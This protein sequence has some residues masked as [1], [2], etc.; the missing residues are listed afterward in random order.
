MPLGYYAEKFKAI[1]ETKPQNTLLNPSQLSLDALRQSASQQFSQYQDKMP[2]NIQSYSLAKTKRYQL[3]LYSQSPFDRNLPT[4]IFFPGGGLVFDMSQL[5]APVF[6]KIVESA[7]VNLVCVQPRLAP[8]VKFLQILEDVL[9]GIEDL[10]KHSRKYSLNM[11]EIYISGYSIG[12]NL[13]LL[14]TRRLIKTGMP[15]NGMILLSGR[16]DLS[17]T[18]DSYN[19]KDVLAEAQLDFMS[20]PESQK[21]FKKYYLS[22]CTNPKMPDVSPIYA[23]LHGLPLSIIITGS[24]DALRPDSIVLNQ[25]L[26]TFGVETAFVTIPGHIH[27]TLL[28]FG[29]IPDDPN[30]AVVAG[31][32]LHEL[33]STK[34]IKAAENRMKEYIHQQRKWRS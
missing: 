12:G 11:D 17:F 19:D 34:N 18:A 23:D 6:A 21:F 28:C 5:H 15:V 3:T 27:N 9:L 14:A 22:S 16:Y 1:L 29:A 30:P 4:V 32:G 26:K 10:R 2:E 13:A 8:E 31:I 25:R 7:Q 20:N 24:C 33:I